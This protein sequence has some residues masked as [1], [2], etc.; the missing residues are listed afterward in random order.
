MV[1]GLICQF[2]SMRMFD[3]QHTRKMGKLRW[4]Q[5]PPCHSRK[6]S[7][8]N[9]CKSIL[10]A[11]DWS[12]KLQIACKSCAWGENPVLTLQKSSLLL[13]S[14]SQVS[15]SALMLNSVPQWL[16]IACPQRGRSF[17]SFA[18]WWF[19]VAAWGRRGKNHVLWLLSAAPTH[20]GVGK[21]VSLTQSSHLTKLLVAL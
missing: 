3:V 11:S 1:I 6:Y 16:V 14:C 9:N 19:C 8:E 12:L 2:C 7:W 13:N 21:P 10:R 18:Q 5:L 20:N 17:C 15:H 4:Q